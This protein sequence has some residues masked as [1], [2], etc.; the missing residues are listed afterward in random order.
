MFK[1]IFNG[2]KDG[3]ISLE[4][5]T[6]ILVAASQ[7]A[8]GLEHRCGGHGRCGTCR[9]TVETGGEHL[10]PM[11]VVE[12][13]VLQVLRAAPDQRLGCQAW[14]KGDVTCRID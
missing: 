7:G 9:V 14:A 13:R 1:I 10:S 12:G 8:V 11:G 5:E 2:K 6:S 4:R 3:E